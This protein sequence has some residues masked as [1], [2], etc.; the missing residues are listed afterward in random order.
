[1][2][3]CLSPTSPHLLSLPHPT[4]PHPSCLGLIDAFSLSPRWCIHILPKPPTIHH[5]SHGGRDWCVHKV[6]CCSLLLHWLAFFLCPCT[7]LSPPPYCTPPILFFSSSPTH[8]SP[9]HYLYL[10]VLTFPF[11]S[12]R[13]RTAP[14]VAPLRTTATTPVLLRNEPRPK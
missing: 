8:P 4:S 12:S 14:I 1:M 6:L 13:R 11:F 9:I 7:L 10:F 3:F 2:L 5:V